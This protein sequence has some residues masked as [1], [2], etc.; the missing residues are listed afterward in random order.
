[1]WLVA[2]LLRELVPKLRYHNPFADPMDGP[3]ARGLRICKKCAKLARTRGTKLGYLTR[4]AN[5]RRGGQSPGGS[6][7]LSR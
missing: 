2:G 4:I 1:M 5:S 3:N 6:G 7:P